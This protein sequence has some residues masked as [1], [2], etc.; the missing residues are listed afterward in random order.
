MHTCGPQIGVWV[1]WVWQSAGSPEKVQLVE[2]G[3]GRGTMMADVL[4]TIGQIEKFRPLLRALTVHM[5]MPRP[6]WCQ[7]VRAPPTRDASS[8]RALRLRRRRCCARRSV[9]R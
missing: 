4:R 3:P 8:Q 7:T 9:R 2:L 1:A 5:V 6:L